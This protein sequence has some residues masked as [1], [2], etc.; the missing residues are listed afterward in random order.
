MTERRRAFGRYRRHKIQYYRGQY[1]LARAKARRVLKDALC[2]SLASF[3]STLNVQTPMSQV[4]KRV[5]KIAGKFSPSP[6]PVLNVNGDKISDAQALANILAETFSFVS[7]RASR[8][9]AVRRQFEPE[10]ARQ[11]DFSSGGGENYYVPYS[12]PEL[13]SALSL[14][15]DSSPGSNN[16]IYSIIRHLDSGPLYFLLG[17]FNRMWSDGYVPPFWKSAIVTPIPKPGKETSLPLNYRPIAFT[18]CMMKVF[19][20]VNNALVWFLEKGG[21]LSSVQCGFPSMSIYFRRSSAIRSHY[22]P[23]FCLQAAGCE[24]L[25][26]P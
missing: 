3:V 25:F 14:C 11:L 16:I 13:L 22:L 19:E 1:R 24:H 2:K 9:P 4:F 15:K 18:V 5:R 23:S 26:R 6:P 21:H 17:L 8:F 7:S 10:E 12:L 20:I